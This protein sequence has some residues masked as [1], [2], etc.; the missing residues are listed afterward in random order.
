MFNVMLKVFEG[1]KVCPISMS[2]NP[3]TETWQRDRKKPHSAERRT[4][5]TRGACDTKT[6]IVWER[7]KDEQKNH[8][9]GKLA[10][11]AETLCELC[12]GRIDKTNNCD[13]LG[14]GMLFQ[15]TQTS[16]LTRDLAFVCRWG[17]F[18][19]DDVRPSSDRL[20][21]LT[22]LNFHQFELRIRSNTASTINT[23]PH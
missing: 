10:S 4:T 7:T 3:C 23:T 14:L 8:V 22:S 21:Y 2:L 19:I 20:P 6:G 12:R 16:I 5:R 18:S 9:I 13:L 15:C 11:L 1:C 17:V